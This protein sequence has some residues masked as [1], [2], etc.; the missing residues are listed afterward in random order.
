MGLSSNDVAA[1]LADAASAVTTV[2]A[3]VSGQNVTVPGFS[4]TNLSI[5][6]RY[7]LLAKC[8]QLSV[9][10]LIALKAMTGLNPFQAFSGQPISVLAQDVLSSQTLK[11]VKQVRAVQGSGFTVE[12]LN[13]LLRHQLDPIGKYQSDPNAVTA[14]MQS[15][16]NGLKQIQAENQVPPDVL[17]APEA[18]FGYTEVTI[19]FLPAIVSVFLEKGRDLLLSGRIIDAGEAREIGLVQEI[20]PAEEL[21]AR[22]RELKPVK[23]PRRTVTPEE[24]ETACVANAKARLTEECRAGVRAFLERHKR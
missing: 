16:A 19:G 24:L 15:L 20:V 17:A 18:T 8:L 11:F 2:T 9:A 4:L 12:D 10:D 5:C 7:S 23:R 6:Y 22:A 1:I 3:V 14:L 21:E 13:Y